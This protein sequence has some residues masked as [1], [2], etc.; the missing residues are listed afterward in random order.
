MRPKMLP[1]LWRL[2]DDGQAQQVQ[3]P[4][5]TRQ[6]LLAALDAAAGA[7]SADD[8]QVAA[9]ADGLQTGIALSLRLCVG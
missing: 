1:W 6:Q 4:E 9:G 7:T 2:A 8:P 3:V 5:A